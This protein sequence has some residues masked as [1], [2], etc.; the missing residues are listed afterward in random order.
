[1]IRGW[2]PRETVVLASIVRQTAPIIVNGSKVTADQIAWIRAGHELDY[3]RM[4]GESPV[5]TLR[6]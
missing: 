6:G 3:R 2:F 1:M 4:F 5:I